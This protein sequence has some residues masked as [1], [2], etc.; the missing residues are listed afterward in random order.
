MIGHLPEVS[1]FAAAL[2]GTEHFSE[3]RE[4]IDHLAACASCQARLRELREDLTRLVTREEKTPPPSLRERILATTEAAPDFSAHARRVGRLFDL[5]A[6]KVEALLRKAARRDGW[7]VRGPIAHFPV[8][9]G[10]SLGDG[11]ACLVY[12]QPGAALPHPQA[13]DIYDFILAGSLRDAASGREALPGDLL[14][15]PGNSDGDRHVVCTSNSRCFFA[16]LIR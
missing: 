3:H 1:L 8:T 10:R 16:R 4:V 12:L 5:D 9:P 14:H 15:L 7:Q 11:A 13:R 6:Q 2:D